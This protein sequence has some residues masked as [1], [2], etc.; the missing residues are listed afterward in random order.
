MLTADQ[1][2]RLKQIELQTAVMIALNRPEIISALQISEEQWKRIETLK[3]RLSDHPSLPDL[4]HLKPTERRKK[5][6]EF[7]KEIDKAS[8]A[9]NKLILEVLTPEQRAKFE[10]L[11]GKKI[12]VTWPNDELLPEDFTF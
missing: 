1:S 5:M 12:E 6:I 3:D 9:Q 8:A 11:Q 10:K 2:Q 7:L 4:R